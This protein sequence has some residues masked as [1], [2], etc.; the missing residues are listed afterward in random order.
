MMLASLHGQGAAVSALLEA[1]AEVN[2]KD[3]H[4]FTAFRYANERRNS[5]PLHDIFFTNLV[6]CMAYTREVEGGSCIAR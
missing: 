6:W 1:G 3:S 4:G 5:W 2:L